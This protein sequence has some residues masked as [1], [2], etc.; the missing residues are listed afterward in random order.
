MWSDMLLMRF[1][2]MKSSWCII[3]LQDITELSSS[4]MK[5]DIGGIDS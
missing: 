4:L 2:G 3:P 1:P 5:L